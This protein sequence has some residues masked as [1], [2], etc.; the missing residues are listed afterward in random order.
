M[1]PEKLARLA[2]KIIKKRKDVIISLG[3][4]E[5]ECYLANIGGKYIILTDS[6]EGLVSLVYWLTLNNQ[7]SEATE[8]LDIQEYINKNINTIS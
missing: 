2:K 8:A 1:H 7:H 5:H 4:M 3:A 6:S